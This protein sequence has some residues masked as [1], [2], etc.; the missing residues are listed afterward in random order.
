MSLNPS[1]G[2][3]L[4][5]ILHHNV[6]RPADRHL[7]ASVLGE[8]QLESSPPSPVVGSQLPRARLAHLVADITARRAPEA[9]GPH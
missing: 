3:E 2:V 5:H 9:T 7:L 8:T 6:H 4:M 1:F